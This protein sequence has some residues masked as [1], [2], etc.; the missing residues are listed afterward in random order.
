MSR[1]DWLEG[2]RATSVADALV[3]EASKA[4]A[5]ELRAWPPVVEWSDAQA[6]AIFAP[7]YAP[8][9]PAL[10]RAALDLGVQLARW[11]LERDYAAIDHA[12][13]SGAIDALAGEHARLAARLLWQW[14]PEWLL[15]LKGL[16]GDRLT[17]GH[18][19]RVLDAAE[20]R[21]LLARLSSS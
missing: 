10:D 3:V 5:E 18:L 15:E 19:L 12:A 17:R 11:E 13:R 16:A 8:E 20:K 21:A 1:W 7:L 9:A 4:L 6:Q 14:L 2:V